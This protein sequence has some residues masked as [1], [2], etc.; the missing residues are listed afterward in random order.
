MHKK[1]T[2]KTISEAAEKA[3]YKRKIRNVFIEAGFKSIPV[4]NKNYRIGSRNLV[5][6]KQI[7]NQQ[8][9]C[10]Y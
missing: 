6:A 4:S 1:T 8:T 10:F 5:A 3:A 7:N 2:K 9:P